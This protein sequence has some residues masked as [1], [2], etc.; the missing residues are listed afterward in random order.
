MLFGIYQLG[1]N[2]MESFLLDAIVD[3]KYK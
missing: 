2:Y 1:T 3:S